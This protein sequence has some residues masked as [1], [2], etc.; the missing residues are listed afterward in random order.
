MEPAVSVCVSTCSPAGAWRITL[1]RLW[2]GGDHHTV[3]F[4]PTRI[5]SRIQVC[6]D[7]ILSRGINLIF[8]QR[9]SGVNGEAKLRGCS[10]QTYFKAG[11]QSA[12]RSLQHSE[13]GR[14]YCF[15][16]IKMIKKWTTG[17]SVSHFVCSVSSDSRP[18]PKFVIMKIFPILVGNVH[19]RCCVWRAGCFISA[20]HKY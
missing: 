1:Q 18:N 14:S 13:S 17:E 4:A 3:N 19:P 11:L 16:T 10:P 2:G 15:Y 12:Y 5:L 20:L 6:C 8:I 7:L 9:H